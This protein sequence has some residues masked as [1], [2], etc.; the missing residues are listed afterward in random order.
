MRLTIPRAL[1]ALLVCAMAAPASAA[2]PKPPAEGEGAV[3]ITVHPDAIEAVPGNANPHLVPNLRLERVDGQKPKRVS[4][5]PRLTGLQGS[6]AY[7]AALPP[8]RYR[9][10]TLCEACTHYPQL[11]PGEVPEF[12]VMPGRTSYL[13]SLMVATH[14]RE[15]PKEGWYRLHGWEPSPS[16]ALGD[17]LL[18]ALFPE[19]TAF[20]PVD[21][22]AWRPQVGEAEAS[23]A[24]R[25]RIQ[26]LARG[27][28]E[29]T[30]AGAKGFFFGGNVGTARR[31]TPERGFERFDLGVP[32]QVRTVLELG[33]GR[34]IAGGEA[35]TLRLSSD[36]GQS[37]VDAPGEL[38]FGLVVQIM[39]LDDGEVVVS[40]LG[41][42]AVSLYRGRPGQGDWRLLGRHELAF[43][44]WTGTFGTYPEMSRRGNTLAVSLPSK[45]GAVHDL[46]T[47]QSHAFGL[48]GSVGNLS[49]DADGVL[50]CHCRKRVALGLWES[51]DEGRSWTESEL[52]WQVKAPIVRETGPVYSVQGPLARRK[53][54]GIYASEDGGQTWKR[55][56][57]LPPIGWYREHKM[58]AD[59]SGWLVLGTRAEGFV[60]FESMVLSEDGGIT[61]RELMAP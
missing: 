2:A 49:L 20:G 4:I 61:W 52:T 12:E 40:I 30:P 17:R 37:W 38:P 57:D 1:V 54:P 8:G 29:P 11:D 31:W 19:L 7:G 44:I 42:E 53:K 34:L 23:L 5:P 36:D 59:G 56:G 43:S 24:I 18:G 50:R 48:P 39:P 10:K 22:G 14:D 16:Q 35:G 33:E 21:T 15:N 6:R 55:Q 60:F 9:I 41:E 45:A 26:S 28:Y 32:Y 46:A 58:T 3:L 13:G 51:R 27:L 47:G 25:K